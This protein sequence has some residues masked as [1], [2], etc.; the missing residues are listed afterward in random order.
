MFR[1]FVAAAAA[2]A[3]LA[4]CGGGGGGSTTNTIPAENSPVPSP[5]PTPYYPSVSYG[6]GYLGNSG[7]NVQFAPITGNMTASLSFPPAVGTM[8]SQMSLTFDWN[9]GDVV[10]MPVLTTG[11]AQPQGS[12]IAAIAIAP[13]QFIEINGQINGKITVPSISPGGGAYYALFYDGTSWSS[14]QF[15]GPGGASPAGSTPASSDGTIW[16][17][18]VPQTWNFAPSSNYQIDITNAPLAN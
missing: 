10:P 6:G 15:P 7:L 9:P 8:V 18:S 5:T 13:A 11:V 1:T 4:A 14:A 12:L 3:M 17:S 2:L 16:F